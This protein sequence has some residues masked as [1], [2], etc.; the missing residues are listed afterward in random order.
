MIKLRIVV[1]S[2]LL[3]SCTTVTRRPHETE[4]RPSA[5]SS[6]GTWGDSDFCPEG[7]WAAGTLHTQYQ[8]QYQ[9]LSPYL[10]SGYQLKHEP[11]CGDVCDDTALNAVRLYCVTA[12]GEEAGQATSKMGEFGQW[13][14]SLSCDGEQSFITGIQFKSEKVCRYSESII[15]H[16]SSNDVRRQ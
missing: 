10:F 4:L 5:G 7:S 15:N 12:A 8:Y 1:I 14:D 6:W 2:S 13:E 16:K 9:Y 11:S 3:L